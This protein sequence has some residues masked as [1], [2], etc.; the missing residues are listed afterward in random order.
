MSLPTSPPAPRRTFFK[1][2]ASALTHFVG[3]VIALVGLWALLDRTVSTAST[4]GMAVYGTSLALLFLASSIYHFFDIG[5]QGNRWLQRLDHVA[6]FLLI[7][8]TYV[9]VCLWLLDGAWRI[10]M[11][12][13]IGV[14]ALAGSVL[15]LV[16]IDCPTRLSTALYL[17]LG[18]IVIIPAHRIFPQLTTEQLAWL[19][20]GGLTYTLG[21]LVYVAERPDPWP[22]VFGHH[23]VWHLFVLGGAAAHFGFAWTLLGQ[24]MPA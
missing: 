23:D 4:A 8:G 13:L 17:A 19:V 2:P 16:W 3:F 5:E 7:A 15:K 21:A 14:I 10:G 20:G 18:W 22:R 12:V 1:D 9:P 24:P 11:L 6:I